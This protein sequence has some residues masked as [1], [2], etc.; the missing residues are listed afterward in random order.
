MA[1]PIQSIVR[2]G[3]PVIFEA[4]WIGGPGGIH[5]IDAAGSAFCICQPEIEPLKILR[6]PV[7]SYFELNIESI[8]A[9]NDAYVAS[10]ELTTNEHN[11]S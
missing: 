3:Y 1:L 10:V 11:N 9:R 6:I 5:Y 7:F 2:I 4:L 8:D